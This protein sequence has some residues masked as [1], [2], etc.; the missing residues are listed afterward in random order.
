MRGAESSPGFSVVY[1]PQDQREKG[2]KWWL[3]DEGRCSIFEQETKSISET[4]AV[5][6]AQNIYLMLVVFTS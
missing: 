6:L 5:G 3:F 4:L 2:K 1:G